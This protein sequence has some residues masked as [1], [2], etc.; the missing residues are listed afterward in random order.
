[1]HGYIGAQPKPITRKAINAAIYEETGINSISI[2][3]LKTHVP[4]III[5]LSPSLSVIKPLKNLPAVMPM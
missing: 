1:M 4:K 2:P 3:R 5:F